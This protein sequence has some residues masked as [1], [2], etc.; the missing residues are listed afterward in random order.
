MSMHHRAKDDEARA[1]ARLCVGS[2]LDIIEKGVPIRHHIYG[3]PGDM[4]VGTS[5]SYSDE[6]NERLRTIRDNYHRAGLAEMG[7]G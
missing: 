5:I 3:Y 1:F 2:I 6:F 4:L 7:H